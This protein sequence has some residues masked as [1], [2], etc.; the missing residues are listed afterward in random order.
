MLQCNGMSNICS[1]ATVNNAMVIV[2]IEVDSPSNSQQISPPPP[3]PTKIENLSSCTQYQMHE[4]NLSDMMSAI[5]L[6]FALQD[7]F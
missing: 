1:N 6:H 3:S 4:P 5:V 7:L 2:I